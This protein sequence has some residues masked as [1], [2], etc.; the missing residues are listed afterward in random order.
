MKQRFNYRL[1]PNKEQE[2]LMKQAGGSC[3][4]LWNRFLS[5]NIDLYEQEKKFL[6]RYDLIM[7]IPKIKQEHI[8]LL[9]TYAQTLQQTAI[10]LGQALTNKFIHK[11]YGFPKFKKKT[12]L[13]DSFRYVQKTEIQG[14]RL[15]LP[16]IGDVKIKLHRTVPKYSSVTIIQKGNKWWASFVVERKEK[17]KVIPKTSIGLDLGITS[18]VTD[19]NGQKYKK[20]SNTKDHAYNLKKK[21]QALSRKD[22]G[23]NNYLKTLIQVINIHL[24]IRSQ[25]KDFLHKLSNQIT[26]DY[27]L[28]CVE[29]LNVKGMVRNRRLSKSISDQGWSEFISMLFYKSIMKGK[30]TIKIDRFVPSSKTCSKCNH[31]QEMPLQNRIYNC[32]ICGMLLD[33]D[34][35]AAINIHRWGHQKYTAGTAGIEACGDIS[36]GDS[37]LDKSRYVPLNQEAKLFLDA[38]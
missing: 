37:S 26:N 19:S 1:Y 7:S 16:K 23:S 30:E 11:S 10:D 14:N 17:P 15:R 33:R 2:L 18:F 29:D 36:A 31:V 35:N 8:W 5:N 22:Y 27:D 38:R 28:I 13:N 4:W 12:L 25:R 3:R 32:S 6:F 24:R 9:N 21:Q 34:I 20:P